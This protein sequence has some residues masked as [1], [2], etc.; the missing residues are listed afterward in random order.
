MKN[1]I[2]TIAK[3]IAS[4]VLVLFS[5]DNYLLILFGNISHMKHVVVDIINPIMFI[6]EVS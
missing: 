6:M 4:L 5:N 1:T 2:N 3:Y